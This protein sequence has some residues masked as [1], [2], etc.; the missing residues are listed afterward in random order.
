MALLVLVHSTLPVAYNIPPTPHCNLVVLL[1]EQM[2]PLPLLRL[3][4]LLW[5]PLGRRE[6]LLLGLVSCNIPPR[7]LCNPAVLWAESSADPSSCNT[8]PRPLCSQAG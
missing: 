7:P 5:P 8:P 2:M 4:P 6:L 1:V 3:L